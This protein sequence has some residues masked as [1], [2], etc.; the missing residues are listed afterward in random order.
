M[1]EMSVQGVRVELPSNS[2]VVLLEEVEG[3]HRTLPIF[4]GTPEA[5]AIAYSLQDVEVPRPMTHD[6]VVA[7]FDTLSAVISRVVITNLR[8]GTFYAELQGVSRGEAFVLSCRPSDA[9]AIAVRSKC[10]IYCDTDLLDAEG[11][12]L[13]EDVDGDNENPD[14]LV[15]EFKEFIEG[16]TPEDFQG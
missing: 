2:P 5:T 4:I 16:I 3:E 10:K 12:I 14:E 8:E 1:I 7:L 15:R 13:D 6:L 9:I 11:V